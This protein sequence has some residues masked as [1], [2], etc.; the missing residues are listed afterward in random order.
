MLHGRVVHRLKLI[1]LRKQYE[2]ID[3]IK[4]KSRNMLLHSRAPIE[5][6]T[7]QGSD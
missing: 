3:R 7:K 5:R 1:E 6:G 4:E 2:E